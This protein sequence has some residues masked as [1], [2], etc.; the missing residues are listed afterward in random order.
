VVLADMVGGTWAVGPFTGLLVSL[1]LDIR[2]VTE[3]RIR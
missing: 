3:R 2:W 1:G